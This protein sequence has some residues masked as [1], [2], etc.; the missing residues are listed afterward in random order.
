MK[1]VYANWK[2]NLPLPGAV[3]YAKELFRSTEEEARKVEIVLFVSHTQLF[4]VSAVLQNTF[5]RTGAQDCSRFEEGAYTGEVSAAM[6]AAAGA[7]SVLIGH[8]ERRKFFAEDEPCLSEKY[9]LAL[10]A[11]LEPVLCIGETL[12][13]RKAGRVEH[14]LDQQIQSLGAQKHLPERILIAYE[15]V[16]AIGTGVNA[17]SKQIAEAHGLIKTKIMQ[18]FGLTPYVLYGGSVNPV[19]I[20]EIL[21]TENVDGV[22]VGGA[23]LKL[24]TF[25]PLVKA[26][27]AR[28]MKNS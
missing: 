22:L 18:Q 11:D 2:L 3:E 20:D 27:A 13:E 4:P 21:D 23:S 16:W 6:C 10:K 7:S 1:L 8:S 25:L 28:N 9:A 19:N 5:L 26:A 17:T 24:E 15:P 14:V 12:E